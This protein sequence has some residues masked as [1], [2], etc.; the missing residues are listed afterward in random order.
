MNMTGSRVTLILLVLFIG[1]AGNAQRSQLTFN[2][3]EPPFWWVGMNN[4]ELQVLIHHTKEDL[5]SYQVDVA[6]EGVTL[7]ERRNVE[8]PHYAFLILNISPDAKPG[9]IPIVFKAGKKSIRHDYE[10]RSKTTDPNRILG[11]TPADVVYLIMPDRFANG[12]VKN[13][14]VP[15]MYQGVYRTRPGARHGGDLKGIINKLDYLQDLG[16]TTLWLNPVLENN[17]RTASYHGY[18]ITDLYQVDRRFGSNSQYVELIN[19]CHARGMKVIQDMV[20]N[21][22]GNDHW[23]FRDLPEKNWIHQFPEFTRSNYRSTVISDPYHATSDLRRMN[24]G[25]FDT[26]MPDVDQT[27]PLFATYLIQNTIWWIEYA[28]ID[29]IRMDTYPYND[30]DFMARWA[31]EVRA[32]YPAFYLVGEVWINSAAT[33]AYWQH[34]VNNKD[35]YS[36]HLPSVTDFP[37]FFAL[38]QALTEQG[39]WDTG[40]M[41]LYEVLSYDFIYPDPRNNL[42][43]PDNHDLSRFYLLVGKD[44][45]RFKMG[46]AFLMTTR[47]IPQ[48]YYGTEILMDGDGAHHPNVRLDF[49]GGWPGDQTNAFTREG[50]TAE[51]NEAFDYLRTLL[52]WR[53]GAEVIHHGKLAHYIPEQNVYVYFRYSE[54]SRVMVIMNGNDKDM[55]LETERFAE[56]VKGAG[57][58]TNV[59]DGTS[60]PD[61]ATLRVPALTTLILELE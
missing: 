37:L 5:R 54:T 55:E 30:K 46:L 18:A 50:R 23:L 25:W 7:K 57:S 13:D 42:I 9:K 8:N 56:H 20:M 21:H 29:G 19:S 6:Y 15:G 31:Q 39:G 53:K 33:T 4:Q 48:I 51:Q 11:V 45:R 24:D 14:S 17:Q 35:G 43:F 44:I 40:L 2:H 38:P 34:G 1:V 47:G 26:T 49:P 3:V 22:I 36:S 12:D 61:I 58:A 28:G 60:V 16:V 32:Q 10:L 59:L 41:R 27:N 52:Q